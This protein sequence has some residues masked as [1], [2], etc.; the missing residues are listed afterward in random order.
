M[1]HPTG[2]NA[3]SRATLSFSEE[4]IDLHYP[5]EDVSRPDCLRRFAIEGPLATSPLQISA[6]VRTEGVTGPPGESCMVFFNVEYAEGPIFWDTFLYP[7]TGSTPWRTLACEIR[8]RGVVRV[9]EMHIRHHARGRL[10]VRNVRVE[11]I[12]PWKDDA[13]VV[14]AIFGDSTDMSIYLPTAFQ[15]GPRLELLLRDR[16]PDRRVDVHSLAEGGEYLQ[17]LIESGRLARE[18]RTLP[19][20]DIAMIRYGLNDNGHKIDPA[21]FRAQLQTACDMILGRFPKT[22]LVLSTTI[23]PMAQAYSRETAAV[24]GARGLRLI[25]LEQHIMRRSAAG[26]GDWHYEPGRRVGRHRVANRPDSPDGLAGNI[27]PNA[28]G[29]QMIAEH[30]FERIEPIVADLLGAQNGGKA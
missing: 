13:E 5:A 9:V 1:S 4:L 6:E 18:L 28:Y 23:P 14:V 8:A 19:R 30:Y 21:A 16:F 27:H 7:A 11:A 15:V 22:R 12:D 29:A 24:A 3:D 20:C 26:D 10:Q 25:E 17:R 2:P